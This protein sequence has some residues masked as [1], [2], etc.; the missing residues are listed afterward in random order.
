MDGRTGGS[1]GL[2]L[3][4]NRASIITYEARLL[5]CDALVDGWRCEQQF[6][7]GGILAGAFSF[8]FYFIIEAFFFA[9]ALV[10]IV[11]QR[12]SWGTE[13]AEGAV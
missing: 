4:A 8:Y 9:S 1:S 11:R 13:Q 12:K 2:M 10:C 6:S 3:R 7:E 5:R